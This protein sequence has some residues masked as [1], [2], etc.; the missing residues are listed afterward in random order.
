MANNYFLDSLTEQEI[1]QIQSL[2]HKFAKLVT[3][4][5]V[6]A[7]VAISSLVIYLIDTCVRSPGSNPLIVPEVLEAITRT[8]KAKAYK[9][10]SILKK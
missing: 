1:K 3:E 5:R 4:E 7:K 9:A 6:S 2:G 8:F 10:F